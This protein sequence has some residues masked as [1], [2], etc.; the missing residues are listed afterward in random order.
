MLSNAIA[1]INQ[2]NK[3]LSKKDIYAAFGIRYQAGKIY[4]PVFGWIAPLL[5]NGNEKVGKGVYTFSTLPT[6]KAFKAIGKETAAVLEAIKAD[7]INGTCNC[8]CIGCYATTGRYVFDNVQASM[9]RNTALAMFS[10]DFVK[11]AI[12]AQIIADKIKIVRIHAAG[13]FFNDTYAFMWLDIVK[14][15]SNVLFW[16]YTKTKYESLFGGL[17]NA[18]IVKSIV[19]INDKKYLNFGKCGQVATMYNALKAANKSVYLCPCGIAGL[20]SDVKCNHCAACARYEYVLFVEHSTKYDS[21]KDD[22]LILIKAI[23]DNQNR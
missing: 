6:N 16:T 19:D 5:K 4:H 20:A 21:S 2:S 22:D 14:T 17:K 18:N 13:D 23:L 8:N 15:F 12:A 1:K 10:I 7:H 3:K 9:M 11:R